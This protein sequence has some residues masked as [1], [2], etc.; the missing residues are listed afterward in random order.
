MPDFT[1]AAKVP[2]LDVPQ[3]FLTAQR[4]NANNQ[5]LL[6]GQQEMQS[7][8]L[9][10]QSK[11]L[12]LDTKQ[13][14]HSADIAAKIR[15]D[16][17]A[18]DK[19]DQ[20]KL[21]S[22]LGMLGEAARTVAALPDGSPEQKAE[23]NSRLDHL[24]ANGVITD[25]QWRAYKQ[26]GPS[27]LVLNQVMQFSDAGHAALGLTGSGATGLVDTSGM[28]PDD[29]ARVGQLQSIIGNPKAAPQ[30]RDVAKAQLDQL[31]GTK[32]D[33]TAQQNIDIERMVLSYAN[34]RQL[35]LA[36]PKV[37]A[38]RA[39]LDQNVRPPVPRNNAAESAIRNI[40][41]PSPS[42][43]TG[44]LPAEAAPAATPAPAPAPVPSPNL[45]PDQSSIDRVYQEG[46]QAPPASALTGSNGGPP[47]RFDSMFDNKPAAA[48]TAGAA[49]PKLQGHSEDDV[50]T[51]ARAAVQRDPRLRE[52][53]RQRLQ[54]LGID[55]GRL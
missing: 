10:I 31:L 42:A 6:A 37:V 3:S 48:K 36:D 7:R 5:S 35:D 18:M 38:Y 54:D 53:Y 16:Y 55:P 28:S 43:L 11:T 45:L 34:A 30:A 49:N 12:D 20:E 21:T 50:L 8:G 33:R 51:Y 29:A 22:H 14:T 1:L 39:Q 15:A 41:Q 25:N 17:A 13:Q 44:N 52:Q 24:H 9:D 47:N 2:T 23:W 27:A 19:A 26:S 4:I 32:G 46:R 40:P